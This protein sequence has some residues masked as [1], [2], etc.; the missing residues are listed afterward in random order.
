[1]PLAFSI[2]EL[3]TSQVEARLHVETGA[4]TFNFTSS[5][6]RAPMPGTLPTG[7]R[8]HF[9]TRVDANGVNVLSISASAED[10]ERPVAY[11]CDV[12]VLDS[13]Q[14]QLNPSVDSACEVIPTISLPDHLAAFAD[15]F[16]SESFESNGRPALDWTAEMPN[17]PNAPNHIDQSI[18]HDATSREDQEGRACIS[19]ELPAVVAGGSPSSSASASPS[20]SLSASDSSDGPMAV[21]PRI[22]CLQP[23]CGRTVDSPADT[24][25]L[26]S[27]DG[28]IACDTKLPNTTSYPRL[29]A[30]IAA[31]PLAPNATWLC[32]SALVWLVYS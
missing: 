6:P 28:T 19:H 21:K 7:I 3:F 10:R 30:Q 1:M 4:I 23:D 29:L 8:V 18:F 17:L 27:P 14:N 25:L 22:P 13:N 12:P 15:C 24:V 32:I 26:S 20:P 11:S 31:N 9:E 16:Y 5:R 2:E